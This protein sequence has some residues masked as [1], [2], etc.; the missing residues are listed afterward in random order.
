[1]EA[2]VNKVYLHEVGS[3]FVNKIYLLNWTDLKSWKFDC[4][5]AALQGVAIGPLIKLLHVKLEKRMEMTVHDK[6]AMR[7]SFKW[8]TASTWGFFCRLIIGANWQ[9]LRP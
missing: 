3:I 8:H 2:K 5:V 6:I 7:V 9:W 4:Y 1:M